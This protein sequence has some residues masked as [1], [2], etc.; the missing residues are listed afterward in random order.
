MSPGSIS[1]VGEARLAELQRRQAESRRSL[2]AGIAQLRA[3]MGEPV[4]HKFDRY[5]H[6]LYAPAAIEKTVAIAEAKAGVQPKAK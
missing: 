6:K 1:G 4:F 3:G 5:L 2:L